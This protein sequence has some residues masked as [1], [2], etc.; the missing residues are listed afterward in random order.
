MKQKKQ[1]AI[2]AALAK[3]TD[4]EKLLLGLIKK[5]KTHYHLT[6]K[7]MIGDADGETSE[8]RK[9][10]KNNPFLKSVINA[11]EGLKPVDGRWG[12]KFTEDHYMSNYKEGNI[13]IS[14]YYLL[15]LITDEEDPIIYFTSN[16]L[17]NNKENCNYIQ[18]FDGLFRFETEYSFLTYEGYKLK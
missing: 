12:I 2:N 3:L 14:E 18:E 15:C 9:I 16:G 11:I 8:K 5:E 17:E 1:N 10:S 4:D 7:Y 13:T 6:I